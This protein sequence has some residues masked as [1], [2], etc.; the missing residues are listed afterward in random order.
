MVNGFGPENTCCTRFYGYIYKTGTKMT[1]SGNIP[2]S[3]SLTLLL[4]FN[5]KAVS[6]IRRQHPKIPQTGTAKNLLDF[7]GR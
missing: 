6:W 3:I 7:E 1:L 4:I 2:V 5:K